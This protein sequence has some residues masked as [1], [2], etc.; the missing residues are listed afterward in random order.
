MDQWMAGFKARHGLENLPLGADERLIAD[1]AE[2]AAAYAAEHIPPRFEDAV[3]TVPAVEKWAAEVIRSAVTESQAR[4]L[5]AATVQRGPSLL[6][7]GA[8]GVGKTHPAYGAM[9]VINLFGIHVRWVVISAA[10]LYARLRPR[11]G[12]DTE[13]EF[14]EIADAPLLAVD[15]IGA[16]KHSEWVEDIN[17][18]LVNRRYE[19]MRPTLFTSNLPPKDT[20]TTPGLSTVLGERVTSRLVEMCEQ[21]AVK[22]PDRRRNP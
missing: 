15:D 2:K 1:R 17:F 5:Q 10:D 9:R 22:G 21:V 18:R 20:P 13:A 11:P 16:A 7:L 19:W 6:L 12:V 4:G 3:P 8:T 14:T